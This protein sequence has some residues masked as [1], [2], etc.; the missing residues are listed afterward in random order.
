MV[1]VETC[2]KSGTYYD[3]NVKLEVGKCHS[4]LYEE[5]K[6]KKFVTIFF[7]SG[8]LDAGMGATGVKTLLSALNIP[9]ISNSSLKRYAR[10]LLEN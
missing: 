3:S 9:S 8:L 5:L 2:T 7:Y 1:T 4:I 10:L 6:Y